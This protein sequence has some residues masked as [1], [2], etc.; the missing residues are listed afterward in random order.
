M[1]AVSAIFDVLKKY[2]PVIGLEVHAQLKTESKIF[3]SASTEFNP[4]TPNKNVQSY[5]IGLPGVLPVFNR[6][7]IEMAI[8]TGLALDCEIKKT[9]I[10]SRKHYFYPDL[11]KGYQLTQYDKPI[12]EHGKLLITPSESEEKVIGITRIHMEEDAGKNTHVGGA[13]FTLVDYNR[14][15]VPLLEI[16][17]EPDIRSAHDA[18]AYLRALRSILMTLEVSDGNMEE[19]SFRC[20]ANVSL[21]PRGQEEFGTRCEIKNI[22]SFRFVQQAINYEILRHARL[23][24][25]GKKISQETRL[26]DSAKKETRSMRSKEDAHDYRYFPDPDLPPLRIPQEWIDRAREDLPE[27][28]RQKLDRY[29]EMNISLAHAQ[30]L[31]E[32]RSISLFFDQVV[33]HAKEHAVAVA[34][35]ILGD[36]L[37]EIKDDATVI[38]R[39]AFA[40]ADLAKLILLKETDKISSTQQKKMFQKMWSSGAKIDDL[41]K[42]EGE[43]VTD[44]SVLGPIVEEVLNNNPEQVQLLK[45]GKEKIMS[46]LTGQV[47][48][49]TKGKAKPPLIQQMIKDKIQEM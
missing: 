10:W 17:S 32:E 2:E 37:R 12:C 14:A 8:R 49:A 7:V 4:E 35:F 13:P 39:V 27:L 34:N 1:G 29:C 24:D 19:G 38:D 31:S 45:G 25:A 47:M 33:T 36:V 20:D 44:V 23:L 21:R 43:Q 26:F 11:S 48:R 41:M 40:P 22:N 46:Y 3:C 15:G 42:Q 16:V 9:S 30:T 28:P 5:C 6:R 18:A